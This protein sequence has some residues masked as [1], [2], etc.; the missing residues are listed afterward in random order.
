MAWVQKINLFNRVVLG[1]LA[2]LAALLAA[3]G[4]WLVSLPAE[5]MSSGSSLLGNLVLF[6]I[7]TLFL[8]WVWG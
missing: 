6:S 1:Y 8:V 2:G 4:S 5:E 7:I 3:L